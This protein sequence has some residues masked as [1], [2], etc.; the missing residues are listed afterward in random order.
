MDHPLERM[1][2]FSD[3]VFAIAITL[4]VLEIE[5][6]HFAGGGLAELGRV[7][8]ELFPKFFAFVLSFLVIGRFWMT[9]HDLMAH[10]KVFDQRLMW[11]NLI[12]L[13]TIAFMPFSTA[14]LGSNLGQIGPALFYNLTLLVTAM[15][16][17]LMVRR[18]DR[19]GLSDVP[20]TGAGNGS[21]SV[22]LGALFAV[23]L[24][25]IIP[26]FSQM[27]MMTIPLW[28]RLLNRPLKRLNS[29]TTS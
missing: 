26:Q 28:I 10:V 20:L 1:V 14:M 13:L 29:P 21:L 6:P 18:I 17:W 27:G 5:V 9:H 12:Y 19:L 16:G 8:A 15:V 11:P 7:L 4:L 24:T 3:A 22:I 23:L 2:F 25:F